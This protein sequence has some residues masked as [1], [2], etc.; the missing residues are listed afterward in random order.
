MKL[1][2]KYARMYIIG[3]IIFLLIALAAADIRIDG[4][5]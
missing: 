3:T 4:H 2:R 1:S 5:L